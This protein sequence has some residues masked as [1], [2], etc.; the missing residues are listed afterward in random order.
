MGVKKMKNKWIDISIPIRTGMVNWPG[1]PPVDIERVSD[2]RRGDSCTLSKIGMGSHTGTHIDAP[3]HFLAEGKP[4]SQIPIEA[5]VGTARV[6]EI[7]DPE[8]IKPEELSRHHLRR[9]ERVLFKT[10]NSTRVWQTT[11]FVE[12]FVSISKEAADYLSSLKV[13]TIGVDYLSVSGFRDDSTFIHEALLRAGIWIIETLDLSQVKPGKYY[14]VCLP[15]K[16]D[17]CDGAPARA[18][19]RPV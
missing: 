4:I 14:L 18:V 16:I 1:D 6:I 15:L 8:S 10:L 7:L 9:G 12:D 19:L 2:V 13:K 17:E 11:R 3:R 5:T